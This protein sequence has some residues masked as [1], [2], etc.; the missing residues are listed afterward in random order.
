MKFDERMKGLLAAPFQN[1]TLSHLAGDSNLGSFL[2]RLMGVGQMLL[3]SVASN[4]VEGSVGRKG[5]SI[6]A[7]EL[8]GDGQ[9]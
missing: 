7:V 8:S 2:H 5:R 4:R 1:L 9:S 6:H 3:P